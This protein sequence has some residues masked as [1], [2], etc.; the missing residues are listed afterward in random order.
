MPQ[1]P[2]APVGP[3]ID[4]DI[5]QRHLVEVIEMDEVPSQFQDKRKDAM[6]I[7]FKFN[8]WN[9]ETGEAI[10]DNNS[11]LMWEHWGF[12]PDGTWR[13]TKTGTAAKA[14]EWT[15]AL[16]S[17]ELTDDEMIE[18]IDSGFR[19]ALMHKKAV[20]DFEWYTDKKSGVQKVRI[21]K[22]RPY[23][24]KAKAAAAEPVSVSKSNT[25]RIADDLQAKESRREA[26]S[27]SAAA[28]LAAA[29]AE[30]REEKQARLRHEL[31]EAEAA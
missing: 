8:V 20:A 28:T 26:S 13:N 6:S 3:N 9:L 18:L 30:T 5:D 23:K 4:I 14:R 1:R 16:M 12:T 7:I 21:I 27:R 22:L 31:E 25:D 11:G 17:R 24:A 19:E 2:D 10:I 15:E 29:H